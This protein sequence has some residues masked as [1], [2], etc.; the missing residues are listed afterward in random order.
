MPPGLLTRHLAQKAWL[1][2][3]GYRKRIDLAQLD[4]KQQ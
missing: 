3:R 4:L 1:R 2:F